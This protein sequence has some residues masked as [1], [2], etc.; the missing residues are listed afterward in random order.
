MGNTL[1]RIMRCYRPSDVTRY[2]A[3]Y[4]AL[5][6]FVIWFFVP[7]LPVVAATDDYI[8]YWT[9][10]EG[11]GRSI[12]DVRGGKN[13]VMTGSSTGFG[14]ASG[15]IG[16]ALGMDGA[17]GLAVVLPDG[18]VAG[19]QG[20]LSVWFKIEEMSDRNVL[21]SGASL[22]DKYLYALFGVDRE[23]RPQFQFRTETNGTDRKVQGD[24]I[25]NRNEWYHLVFT[26]DTQRYRM[27]INGDELT[28]YGENTGRWFS[29]LTNHLFAYRI[30]ASEANPLLGS[31]SGYIDDV[32]IYARALSDDEITILYEEGNI[33]KPTIPGVTA[34]QTM[35]STVPV[36]EVQ[37]GTPLVTLTPSVSPASTV[38]SSP[39]HITEVTPERRIE[40]LTQIQTLL[41][42]IVELHSELNALRS[43]G[44]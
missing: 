36:T 7:S 14:W 34:S 31:F 22:S 5:L 4:G 38:I 18:T 3:Q 21:F 16:N 15:K 40:I 23:G 26:A 43:L 29:D 1:M 20:S 39:T 32:R 19:S 9:F 8:N 6:V 33:G 10:D 24:K 28:L 17:N 41:Q 12:N 35:A 44:H 30:G 27:F 25:L 11:V 2:V 37:L 42:R 13:G